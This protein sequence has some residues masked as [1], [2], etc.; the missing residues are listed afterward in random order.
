M[1]E[2]PF[3]F[4]VKSTIEILVL[5]TDCESILEQGNY[6]QAIRTKFKD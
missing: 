2:I 4:N 5:V 3:E 6:N 1:E